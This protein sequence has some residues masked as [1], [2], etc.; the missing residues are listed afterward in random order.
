MKILLF[1][2]NGQLGWELCRTLAT[3]GEVISLD[4]PE[5]DFASPETL[6]DKVREILPQVIVN[7]AAYTAVDKAEEQ[8][9]LAQ[10]VNGT[11][12]GVL[13][14]TARRLK[15]AFIHFSTDYVFDGNK[16]R[17]YE[18]IDIPHP[19]NIY[20]Q[21]KLAGE[22]AVEQSGGSYLIFRTSWVYSSRRDNYVTKVLQWSRKS[23]ILRVVNDQVGNPTSARMLAEI[24]AQLLAIGKQDLVN[25]CSQYR[26]IYHLAGDGIA[27]RFEFAQEI[28]R[29]D[30]FPKEQL[31][32]EMQ[33]A[34]TSE[35]PT[36]ARRPLYSALKCEKFT[37]AFG[38]RLPPWQ[39]ALRMTLEKP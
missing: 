18:E 11:A 20:G 38:L 19:I 25:W 21:S 27:S 14:E 9:L 36:P 12:T 24:T 35:F 7:P 22:Q 23:T 37:A 31:A 28:L 3:L 5:V 13:A 33:P 32:R 15:I 6:R 30:P 2:K 39:E 10:T 17:P 1:G 4:Y 34:S 26:G 16:N 8:P 29:C